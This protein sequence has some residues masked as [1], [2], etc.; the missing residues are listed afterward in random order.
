MKA[1]LGGSPAN[2]RG[3][4]ASPTLDCMTTMSVRRR[5]VLRGALG[6]ALALAPAVGVLAAHPDPAPRL[7]AGC[8]DTVDTTDSFSMNCVPNVIP[9]MS[10]QL[11]EAEVAMPGWNAI[12]GGAGG[13]GGAAGRH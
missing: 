3:R 12:P 9:D 10:D 7:L 6:L 2:L 5:K 1:G 13:A 4:A 11:T 8:D